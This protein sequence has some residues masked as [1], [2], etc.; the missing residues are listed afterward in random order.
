MDLTQLPASQN[1]V[2]SGS[3]IL[4][5]ILRIV[6]EMLLAQ[7]LPKWFFWNLRLVSKQFN[8][9]VTPL[10]YRHI[11]LS[12]RD[13]LLLVSNETTLSPH[14]LQIARDIGRYTRHV[15]LKGDLPVEHLR[16]VFESLKHLREV[17]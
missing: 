7:K 15:F 5:E 3:K 16:S 12:S 1:P 2:M 13:I 17:T 4:A 14:E 6:I 9:V 10:I 11:V 8:D